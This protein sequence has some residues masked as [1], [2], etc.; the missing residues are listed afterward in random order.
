MSTLNEDPKLRE[1]LQRGEITLEGQFVTGS[2]YTFLGKVSFEDRTHKVVYK[3][4][5][6][7]LPL[8]DFPTNTLS[9]R[10]VAAYE[11]SRALGWNLV[12]LTLYRDEGPLGPGSL[13]RYI[14]HDSDLHYFTFSD[15]FRQRLRPSVLFDLLINNADRKGGHFLVDE[16]DHI[17]LID[18]G[19]CFHEEDKLRTVAW[20]FAG[21]PI[22]RALLADI[23]RILSDLENPNS[24]LRRELACYLSNVEIE[25][26][27][28]RARRLIADGVFPQPGTRRRPYP[29]PPV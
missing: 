17:W 9:K 18:H 3:P 4:V 29:W 12:P 26:L 24:P 27:R 23:R 2:N 6:G 11:L 13:Q 21:E 25:A 28:K 5:R 16:A 1:I 8:W 22:D 7:E 10:E 19:I 20:D 14:E 15:A